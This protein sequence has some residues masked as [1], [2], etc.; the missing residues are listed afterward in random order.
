[1]LV[2]P[3]ETD[4]LYGFDLLTGKHSFPQKNRINQRYLAGI[5]GDKFLVV[6]THDVRAYDLETGDALWNTPR[7]MLTAGQQIAGH[8]IFGSDDFLIPTTT[9]QL[10]R[11]SLDDGTLLQR[12]GTPLSA[13]EFSGASAVM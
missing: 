4:R 13:R 7:D 10:I 8:G 12:R 1:M 9:H 2:T 3:T 11:V 6:G 5:R